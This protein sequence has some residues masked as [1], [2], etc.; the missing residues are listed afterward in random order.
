M[1]ALFMH[2]RRRILTSL[3]SLGSIL[4]LSPAALSAGE[5]KPKAYLL[6][7]V[8]SDMG[9]SLPIKPI[10]FFGPPP[11]FLHF[12]K[13]HNDFLNA[14]RP[15]DYSFGG[16]VVGGMIGWSLYDQGAFTAEPGKV[17]YLG[18][19]RFKHTSASTFLWE[20]DDE[21]DASLSGLNDDQ[22][23]L[24]EGLP[25]DKRVPKPVRKT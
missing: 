24:I 4:S 2:T 22:R 18:F 10:K 12:L 20:V 5:D 6:M 7:T 3:A 13:P 8:E 9:G 16:L 11:F 1:E 25:I 17:V 21:L 23:R 14:V 19:H 15:G